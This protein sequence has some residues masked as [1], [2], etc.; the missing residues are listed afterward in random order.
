KTPNCD[1]QSECRSS[2]TPK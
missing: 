1:E 2:F